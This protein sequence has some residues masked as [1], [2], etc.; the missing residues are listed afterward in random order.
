MKLSMLGSMIGAAI[1]QFGDVE[2]EM[3]YSTIE[4]EPAAI[5]LDPKKTLTP[6]AFVVDSF[7]LSLM[8]DP[9]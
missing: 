8:E 2:V 6:K 4:F 7:G 9:H 5:V 3:K 1:A